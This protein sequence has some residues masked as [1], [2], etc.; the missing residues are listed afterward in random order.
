MIVND[1][2]KRFYRKKL[3]AKIPFLFTDRT[4]DTT[5][6]RAPR[7]VKR[8]SRCVRAARNLSCLL[9]WRVVNSVYGTAFESESELE[10][11]LEQRHEAEKRDHRCI[12]TKINL[13]SIDATA[14]PGLPPITRT[15]ARFYPSLRRTLTGLT[16]RL[17]TS[18]SR[19]LTYSRS[20]SG[21]NRDTTIT[22]RT[23]CYWSWSYRDLPIRYTEHGKFY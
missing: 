21:R 16:R 4:T 23:I 10:T 18:T 1:S 8:G 6:V 2:K 7:G 19:Q 15:A 5:S 20:T 9:A 22:T 12:G 11:F 13:F 14:S 3:L 17:A